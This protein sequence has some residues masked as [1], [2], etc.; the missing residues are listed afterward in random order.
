LY[1]PFG[2][3]HAPHQAP[4]DYLANYRG[5]F[6]EG[7]DIVRERWFRAQLE[8]GVIPKG[9]KLAPRNPGVDAW[10][11]LPE[12]QKKFACRL[13]EAEVAAAGKRINRA[14]QSTGISGTPLRACWFRGSL[15][16]TIRAE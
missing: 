13:Q 8:R 12:N 7:W 2:A 4:A 10:D 15:D 1:V 11:G 16:K 9:T 6:D 14:E 5:K 3:T